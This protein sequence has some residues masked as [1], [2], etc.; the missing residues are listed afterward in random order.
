[1]EG[2]D[3]YKNRIQYN[4]IQQT[5]RNFLPE[6][7]LVPLYLPLPPHSTTLKEL[8]TTGHSLCALL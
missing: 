8:G 5:A 7:T 2:G 3:S 4:N 1:M 6:A